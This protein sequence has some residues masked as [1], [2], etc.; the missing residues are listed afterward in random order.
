MKTILVPTDFSPAAFNAATY[1]IQLAQQFMIPQITLYH[2]YELPMVMGAEMLAPASVIEP[3]QLERDV[4][5]HMQ[6]LK[7]ALL[8]ATDTPV[9]IHL[10]TEMNRLPFGISQYA[11]MQGVSFIVMSITGGG[12]LEEKLIGSTALQVAETCRIPVMIVP[13]YCKYQTIRQVVLCSDT[14]QALENTCHKVN[15][16]IGKAAVDLT[17]VHVNSSDTE[18]AYALSELQ[19]QLFHV[20]KLEVMTLVNTSFQKAVNHFVKSNK[21]DLL[22]L[23]AKKHKWYQHWFTES[24]T[25]QMAFQTTVP[26][27]L[28]NE[29]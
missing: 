7:Q 12:L 5:Q 19:C 29:Q 14:Q 3:S 18:P 6:N 25:L 11:Q 21:S 22:L 24:H 13:K 20:S 4:Q 27:L 23:I 9:T 8:D 26:M 17:V 2:A 16:V 28:I 15:K 1:A 10:H